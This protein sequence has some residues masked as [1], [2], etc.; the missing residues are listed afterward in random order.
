M[1]SFAPTLQ[2]L[3]G[4]LQA[5][6]GLRDAAVLGRSQRAGA[7]R[8]ARRPRGPRASLGGF[9]TGAWSLYS[10]AG[11]ESTLAYHQLTTSFLAELCRRTERDAVLPRGTALRPLRDGAA[12]DRDRAA[13]AGSGRA[14][15]RR[16]G[17]RSRRARRCSVR[18]YGP[19]GVVLARDMQ[20]GRGGHDLSWTPP[21]RGRFRVRVS[22]RG[23]EGRVG[24]EGRSVRRGAAEAK[25]KPKPKARSGRSRR[26]ARRRGRR[27]AGSA[28]ASRAA[29]IRRGGPGR[30]ASIR[31]GGPRPTAA[32]RGGPF[33]ASGPGSASTPA[34][35]ADR[36]APGVDGVCRRQRR[37]DARAARPTGVDRR[38][39]PLLNAAVSGGG[40]AGGAGRARRPRRGDLDAEAVLEPEL[41]RELR[42]VARL[43]VEH[44]RD[45]DAARARAGGAADAVDVVLARLRRV[46]VDDVR[47][48]GRRRCRARRR[49]SRRACRRGRTRSGR[50][51]S[52]AAT[53]TCRRASRPRRRRALPSRLTS[54]S[55]PRLV[56]TK[57]S[58]S[59]RFGS[60]Q[61]V[62][63]RGRPSPRGRRGGSGA[64]SWPTFSGAGVLVA[65]RRV[66]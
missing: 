51:P 32:S 13:A 12:A 30:E 28:D 21:S 62:H 50:A 56:R 15:A 4:E 48:A 61:L 5:V 54:R 46:V 39:G 23:P 1:Y 66:V 58:V 35:R 27:P 59:P 33:G 10:A 18:V 9:D 19:R 7:A 57:T 20:L 26:A 29:S 55:A 22:A 49:R 14:A 52:R 8:R 42:D 31:R 43:V 11:G 6:N 53:A 37:Y 64:R 3:N 2:I 44:E 24:V 25:P 16:C 41:G 38:S 63:Q 40:V 17:S 45:A 65:A 36:G 34:G 60:P 47:D